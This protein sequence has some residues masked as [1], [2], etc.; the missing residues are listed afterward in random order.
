MKISK[1]IVIGLALLAMGFAGAFSR[2]LPFDKIAA[3]ANSA[4]IQLFSAVFFVLSGFL[5]ALVACS[6]KDELFESSKNAGKR[7]Q[8]GHGDWPFSSTAQLKIGSVATP[9]ASDSV[10]REL[11]QKPIAAD[12]K[13][14]EPE[15]AKAPPEP[16][17][18]QPERPADR[19]TDIE[20]VDF[21]PELANR[22]LTEDTRA[23]LEDR[24]EGLVI[25]SSMT[26]DDILAW[27]LNAASIMDEFALLRTH[28]PADDL[29]VVD[30]VKQCICKKLKDLNLDLIDKDTWDPSCQRAVSV[31]RNETA[32]EPKI[33]KKKAC[34]MTFKG[35]VV[36]KQ[37]VEVEMPVA[38]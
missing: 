25:D 6:M 21:R 15:P 26:E 35:M 1:N 32:A 37:E 5:F 9:S 7:K 16:N 28:L 3:R 19:K 4:W 10:D 36:K 29:R 2:F 27:G 33:L 14:P 22:K 31:V 34:G 24:L 8:S 30:D 20:K 11:H 17:Q 38:R 23:F 18:S 12:A 13:E